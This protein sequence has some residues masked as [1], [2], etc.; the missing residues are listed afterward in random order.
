MPF[1]V[2]SKCRSAGQQFDIV[3]SSRPAIAA[4]R[5]FSSTRGFNGAIG[6][7]FHFRRLARLDQYQ[8][9]TSGPQAPPQSFAASAFSKAVVSCICAMLLAARSC[10]Y[11]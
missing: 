2:A 8:P 9:G 6:E 1:A 3:P 7:C 11:C 5:A 10:W 4:D